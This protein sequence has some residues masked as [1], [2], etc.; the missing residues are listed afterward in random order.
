MKKILIYDNKKNSNIIL[1]TIDN[2]NNF[3]IELYN[4]NIKIKDNDTRNYIS[5]LNY[6][7]YIL[8][9][10]QTENIY[11]VKRE[12]IYN[13]V[14]VNNYR[15][16]NILIYKTC[17]KKLLYEDNIEKK[18]KLTKIINFL[19]NFN[20]E[21]LELN[22]IKEFNNFK[23]SKYKEYTT[24]I[25]RSYTNILP[26]TYYIK[27]YFNLNELIKNKNN[28]KD[29]NIDKKQL[30]NIEELCYNTLLRDIPISKLIEHQQHIIYNDGTGVIQYYS[31]LGSYI[32]NNYL[33]D[34]NNTYKNEIIENIIKKIW[35]LII[36]APIFEEDI[37]IYRF[38]TNDDFLRNLEI[39]D[40]YKDNGFMSTTRDPYFTSTLY[41]FGNNLMK[42]KIPKNKKGIGLCLELFSHFGKEQEILLAPLTKLKLIKK[43]SDVSYEHIKYDI[44]L[45][46]KNKYEF[47]LVS[48]SNIKLDNK[49][50]LDIE[51]INKFTIENE[52][53]D[54]LEDSL[55]YIYNKLKE[56]Y[57]N[58]NNQVLYKI[59]KKYINLIIE[60]NNIYEAY[61][62]KPFYVGSNEKHTETVLIY[63]IKDNQIIFFIEINYNNKLK[64]NEINVNINNVYNHNDILLDNIFNTKDFLLF[65]KNIAEIFKVKEIQILCDFISCSYFKN[66]NINKVIKDYKELLAG[67]LNLEIYY[68][69]K[70][71]KVRF[72][73]YILDDIIVPYFNYNK[74]DKYK[75]TNIDKLLKYIESN[76]LKEI[77]NLNINNT[78]INTIDKFYIYIVEKF[79]F[80]TSEL[81]HNIAKY[82]YN[83]FKDYENSIFYS[84]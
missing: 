12:D 17:E 42:I 60:K 70:E 26:N 25:R 35:Q 31:L 75:T 69:F 44:T 84:P 36:N 58:E 66:K 79:C 10:I 80:L 51:K 62:K 55:E 67:N 83:E 56:K 52:I 14:V 3:L 46:I 38:L 76:E 4:D 2:N 57:L 13:R 28:N 81:I 45:N 32:L 22:F 65:L 77:I 68:Y 7:L 73:K 19:D 41:N 30:E 11:L 40:I 27:P 64:E 34:I 59:G 50:K 39:G 6:K 29:L 24:C 20:L 48:S 47:E 43:D 33:R 23:K 74:L 37:Y 5:K 71:N 63:H 53:E 21:I 49:K 78:Q 54:S 9:D 72:Q 18:N 82:E 8:Y 61:Y 16:P 1:E 15:F